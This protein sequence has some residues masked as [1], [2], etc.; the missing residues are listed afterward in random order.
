V[1]YFRVLPPTESMVN[2]KTGK[3]TVFWAVPIHFAIRPGL[4]RPM[5]CP[6]RASRGEPTCAVCELW[7]PFV[8][9]DS[10]ATAQEKEVAQDHLPSWQQYMNILLLD[11]QTGEPVREEDG[12]VKVRVYGAG[13][14][15]IDQIISELEDIEQ[16]TGVMPD[17]THPKTGRVIYVKRVGTTKHDTKYTPK[18]N[19]VEGR[20]R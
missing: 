3:A 8:R 20:F 10:T 16:E 6:R 11:P 13:P 15:I 14:D 19:F 1:Y 4:K 17:I 18:I 5:Y 12:S 2:P 9:K 7:L